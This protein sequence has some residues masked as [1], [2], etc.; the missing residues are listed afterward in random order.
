M[1]VNKPE[2][3]SWFGGGSQFRGSGGGGGGGGYW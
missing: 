1:D 2:R 3:G